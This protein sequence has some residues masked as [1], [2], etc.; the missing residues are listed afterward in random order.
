MDP[1]IYKSAITALFISLAFTPFL[2][3]ISRKKGYYA[4][5]N[6][7]SSHDSHVPNTG[8]IILSVAVLIPLLFF[9][10]YPQKD[11]FSLLISA[12]SVLL[13]TGIIDDFNPIPVTFKFL[14]QF[15]PAIV[16]VTSM[17][18]SGLM[19]PFLDDII[20]IPY[21]FSYLFWIVFIV[22]SINAFNLID[23]IDGLAIGLG[24]IGSLFYF[25][26]FY[27]MNE[28]AL[29]VFSISLCFGLTGLLV[30]NMSKKRKIFIGDTGSLMIGGLLVFFALKMLSIS[31]DSNN[32]SSFFIILGS[33][34]IPL[35]DMVRVT[36]V[37]LIDGNSPFQADREHIHHIVLDLM[38]GNHWITTGILI[39]S[40]LLIVILF[41]LASENNP[42]TLM[43]VLAVAFGIYI[44]ICTWLNKERK[45]KI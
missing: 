1:A 12:L 14:G 28:L 3:S 31:P 26:L 7:R 18:A 4:D 32:E 39:I 45:S 2:I 33:I 43:I 6:H 41:Y 5:I 23:G 10:D 35:S 42:L 40:Q 17:D 25:L 20:T 37:R 36:L 38:K 16:I 30:Y 29:M 21:F 19:I 9:S 27:Q 24:I 15:I 44:G 8:G 22:M 13:I 34:F 11:D